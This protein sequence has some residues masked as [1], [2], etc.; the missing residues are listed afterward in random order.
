MLEMCMHIAKHTYPD[1]R[2]KT[3]VHNQFFFFGTALL[4]VLCTTMQYFA[5]LTHQQASNI[6]KK[7]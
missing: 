6:V 1:M 2:T 5:V 4:I 7:R 3:L